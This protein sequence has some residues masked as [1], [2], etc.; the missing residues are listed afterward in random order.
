MLKEGDKAPVF[1]LASDGGRTIRSKDF[2]GRRLLV[3]FYPKDSTPGCTREAIGFTEASPRIEA[4]GATVVGVSKDSVA[5]HC[6]FRD[7]Y[8]LGIPLLSDPDLAVHKAFGAYGEKTMYGKKVEGVIRSTFL[9]GPTGVIEKVW[10]SV[11]VDAHVDQ[12]LAFLG[13]GGAEAGRKAPAKE[14][15]AKKPAAKK[16][17]AS[18]RR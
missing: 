8:A 17:G 1:E 13:G 11:K 10:P 4:L 14:P 18:A 15:V 16:A 12:V 6:T 7:K 9:V 5:S 2:A 3:Y